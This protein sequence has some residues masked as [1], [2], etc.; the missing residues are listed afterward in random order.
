MRYKDTFKKKWD[1]NNPVTLND[2]IL[3]LKLNTYYNNPLVKQC[4]DKYRVREYLEQ[5]GCSNILNDLI[6]VYEKA[7]DIEWDKL[8]DKFAL[9]LN[10]GCGYN[11]IVHDKSKLDKENA[12]MKIKKWM[13][14]KYYRAYSEMQY[15]DV[16]P[17]ILIEKYLEPPTG[18]S[19]I[20]YKVYCFHGKPLAI[21]VMH[22]R[23]EL[24]K[25]EF[26]D[27]N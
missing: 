15:K 12:K 5:K 26:F 27:R 14:E 10:T 3:W 20:D 11:I 2:K 19:L 4:A 25:T 8:P 24:M 16:K 22:D 17:Y 7:E 13:K 21:L 23:D 6:A 1:P 9:K 18:K